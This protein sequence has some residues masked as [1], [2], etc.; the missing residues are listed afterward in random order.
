MI[1]YLYFWTNDQSVGC[2]TRQGIRVIWSCSGASFYLFFE[3]HKKKDATAIRARA[4]SFKYTFY[5]L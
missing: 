4:L 1:K 2:A 3:S 5:A